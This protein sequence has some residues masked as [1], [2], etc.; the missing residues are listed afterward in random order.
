MTMPTTTKSTKTIRQDLVKHMQHWQGIERASVASTNAVLEKTNHPL[1]RLVM[2]IIRHDSEL[3]ERIQQFIIDDFEKKPV[4]LSPD[5][6][7]EVSSILDHHLRLEDQ[8]VDAVNSSIEKVKG[9]KLLVEEYLLDFLVQDERK[10]A[11]MLRALDKVKQ[12]IYPYA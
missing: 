6:M 4:S 3:H 10:H 9:H 7:G 5:E 1:L 12:G 11:G 8:M 2:E